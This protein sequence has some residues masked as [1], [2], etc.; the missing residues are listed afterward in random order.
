MDALARTRAYKNIAKA[1]RRLTNKKNSAMI[2]DRTLR[3][4]PLARRK[5]AV[6]VSKLRDAN[7]IECSDAEET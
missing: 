6:V 5:K 7:G 3:G 2:E 1:R 4:F